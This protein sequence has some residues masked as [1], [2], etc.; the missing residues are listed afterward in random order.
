MVINYSLQQFSNG[1]KIYYFIMSTPDQKR[2]AAF[3]RRAVLR[4]VPC[5]TMVTATTIELF[6]RP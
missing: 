1:G 5:D 4:S 2:L 3:L 6:P